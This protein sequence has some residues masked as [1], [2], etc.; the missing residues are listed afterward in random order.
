MSK[1]EFQVKWKLRGLLKREG[2]TPYALKNHLGARVSQPTVYA[3][4]NDPPGK[5]DLRVL[6][7]LLQGVRE[8]SGKDLELADVLEI[9]F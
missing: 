2:I 3:Y 8:L 5:P 7:S 4:V 6:G 1:G 9:T